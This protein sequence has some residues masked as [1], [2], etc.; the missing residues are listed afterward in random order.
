M[1]DNNFLR[2]CII[3]SY[4]K[5]ATSC[6]DV[7]YVVGFQYYVNILVLCICVYFMLMNPHFLHV[8]CSMKSVMYC[9]H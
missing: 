2:G 8:C 4:Q 9:V 1:K 7:F 6:M 3:Q 5:C